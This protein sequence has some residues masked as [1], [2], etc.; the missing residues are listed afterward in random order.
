MNQPRT[1]GRDATADIVIDDPVFPERQA[2]FERHGD[3]VLLRDLG[4]PDGCQVNGVTVRDCW[5]HAGDQIVFDGNQRFVLEVPLGAAP[6]YLPAV[7]DE[8]A[9]DENMPEQPAVPVRP[10]RWPWLLLSALLLGATISAL[11]FGAR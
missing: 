8:A 7:V 1:I 6:L 11:L 3:K 2:R 9:A 10:R 5:L 4:S